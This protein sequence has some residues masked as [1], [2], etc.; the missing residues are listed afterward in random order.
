MRRVLFILMVAGLVAGC[1][2]P[3]S[4]D[5]TPNSSV[6]MQG[7]VII[8]EGSPVPHPH[9]M[10]F[11]G[12]AV[13]KK[14]LTTFNKQLESNQYGFK[15]PKGEPMPDYE[16]MWDY[17]Y[18]RYL[19]VMRATSSYEGGEIRL[20]I[21]T[22]ESSAA[23]QAVRVRELGHVF[24]SNKEIPQGSGVGRLLNARVAE[25]FYIVWLLVSFGTSDEHDIV[26]ITHLNK[27]PEWQARS[28]YKIIDQPGMARNRLTP[29]GS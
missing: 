21:V 25:E 17:F 15:V 29:G 14:E 5:D 16:M 3:K 9:T 26:T 8:V 10:R 27:S 12:F 6:S 24:N 4:A 2:V 13:N 19:E 20:N 7:D 18:A 28:V 23:G 11:H 1:K 22:G